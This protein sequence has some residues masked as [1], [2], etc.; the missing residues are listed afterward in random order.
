MSKVDL[1]EPQKGRDRQTSR[2]EKEK[3][4]H[5]KDGQKCVIRVSRKL[6]LLSISSFRVNID[7][8]IIS[9]HGPICLKYYDGE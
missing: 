7:A 6:W 2:G 8:D 5:A 3:L 4:S 1:Q 9:I